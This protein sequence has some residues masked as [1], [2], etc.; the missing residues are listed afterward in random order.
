MVSLAP[1]K[2]PGQLPADG[3]GAILNQLAQSLWV[4]TQPPA[5]CSAAL[6]CMLDDSSESSRRSPESLQQ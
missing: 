5:F 2:P 6:R 1:G 3:A 4:N